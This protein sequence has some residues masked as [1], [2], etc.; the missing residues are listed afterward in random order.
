MGWERFA[1]L[2]V[3]AGLPVFA[4]GGQ[5]PATVA[6]ARRHGA[7]GIAGIRSIV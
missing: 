5:S 3:Q 4:I 1:A 2:A 7:H 6:Q